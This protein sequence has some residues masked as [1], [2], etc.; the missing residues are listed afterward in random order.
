MSNKIKYLTI[1]IILITALKAIPPPGWTGGY[2]KLDLDKEHYKLFYS[3]NDKL[4]ELTDNKYV[5]INPL[6][7]K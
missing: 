5:W 6:Y 1:I 3:L 2:I 4:M 7:Y